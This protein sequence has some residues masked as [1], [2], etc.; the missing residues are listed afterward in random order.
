MST[1]PA[2][3]KVGSH[4]SIHDAALNH[5]LNLND[6]LQDAI[7]ENQMDEAMDI[8][9]Q[10]IDIWE[11]RIIEH[12]NS[13][14]ESLYKEMSAHSEELAKRVIELTREHDI[15]RVLLA[16][17]K[18]VLQ[19]EGKVTDEAVRKFDTLIIVDEVH[20]DYEMEALELFHK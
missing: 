20:N 2:L 13:E 8:S 3:R 10:I 9:A 6:D 12:A 16:Q 15:L 19:K 18:E 14:E 17:I 4:T 11:N 7:A 1:G 5:A